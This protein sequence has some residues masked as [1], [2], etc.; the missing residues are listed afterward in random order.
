MLRESSPSES[1][2]NDCSDS[3]SSTA[4]M[5]SLAAIPVTARLTSIAARHIISDVGSYYAVNPLIYLTAL[6]ALF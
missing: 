4:G 1:P 3:R 2:L 6:A 5:V